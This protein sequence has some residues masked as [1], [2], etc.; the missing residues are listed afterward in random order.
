MSERLL[1]GVMGLLF[2]LGAFAAL[3]MAL[4]VAMAEVQE[5]VAQH[6]VPAP[7]DYAQNESASTTQ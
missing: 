1:V 4:S 6:P 2:G 3:G 7:S 5:R